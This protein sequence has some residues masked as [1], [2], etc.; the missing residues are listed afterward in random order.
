MESPPKKNKTNNLLWE[1][2][3][4]H[5]QPRLRLMG[6]PANMIASFFC[7]EMHERPEVRVGSTGIS[8]SDTLDPLRV[9]IDVRCF[10]CNNVVGH[11]GSLI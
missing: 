3:P 10:T 8:F 4:S 6:A 5:I 7:E 2:L 1:I 11:L 9:M